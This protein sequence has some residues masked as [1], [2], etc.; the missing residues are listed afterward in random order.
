MKKE[1]KMQRS[2][3]EFVDVPEIDI[4]NLDREWVGQPRLRSHYAD[5]LADAKRE[6]ELASAKLEE[7]KA[8]IARDIRTNPGDYDVEKITE[9]T[10]KELIPLQAE[11]KEALQ[12]WIEAK[13]KAD[14]L[15]GR[16]M[17]VNDRKT[18]LENLVELRLADYFG[19]PRAKS[20]D[21]HKAME[22]IKTDKAF[23]RMKRRREDD[24][25]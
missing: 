17:A 9:N 2:E 23:N 24:D 22:K 10:V 19:E 3:T 8:E 11:Y 21:S 15:T 14:I 13:H 12:E 6:V 1:K 20:A 16:S 5:L 18:S 4:N 25:D 7:V